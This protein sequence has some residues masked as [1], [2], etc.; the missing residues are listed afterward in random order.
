MQR[1][2]LALC[3]WVCFF[4]DFL[5]AYLSQT[6]TFHDRQRGQTKP[7]PLDYLAASDT[8]KSGSE[9]SANVERKVNVQAAVPNFG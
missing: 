3:S 4:D 2:F 8:L 1:Q 5:L 9:R 6:P 7:R